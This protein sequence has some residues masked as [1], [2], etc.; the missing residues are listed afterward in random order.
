MT[1]QKPR[2]K[3]RS[4]QEIT[5]FVGWPYLTSLCSKAKDSPRDQALIAALFLTGGRVH[6][7]LQLRQSSF[8]PQPGFLVCTMTVGKKYKKQKIQDKHGNKRWVTKPTPTTRVFPIKASEPLVPF[9][10]KWLRGKKPDQPLFTVSRIRV[11]QLTTKLDPDIYPHW[12]RAQRASQLAS[13]YGYSVHQLV[14]Y[15][16]WVDIK[17]AMRYSHLGWRNLAAQMQL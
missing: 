12:F 8:K 16:D 9:L 15:F 10:V 4:V 3:R 2:R 11:Y 14:E 7:V 6:E 17:T 1:S 13:E 5:E